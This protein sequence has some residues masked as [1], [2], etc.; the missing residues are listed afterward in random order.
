MTGEPAG[1]AR[2]ALLVLTL[3][4]VQI[5]VFADLQL[6]GVHPDAMLALGICAGLAAGPVRGSQVGFAAGLLSDLVL[7]GALG[8]TAFAFALVGFGA[9]AAGDAVLRTSKLISVGIVAAASSAGVLLYAAVAQLLGERTLSDPRLWR[10]VAIVTLFNVVL[11]LP[12]LALCKWA[13]GSAVR[14]GLR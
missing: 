1:L 10:I 13:E 9:G 8:T 6:F 3:Y 7:Q 12:M 4:V 5:G 14:V 2:W 11:C